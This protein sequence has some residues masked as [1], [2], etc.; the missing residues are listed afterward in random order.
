MYRRATLS[1]IE[2]QLVDLER[3]HVHVVDQVVE[4]TQVV[5][6]GFLDHALPD[7]VFERKD[8]NEGARGMA[9]PGL[10]LSGE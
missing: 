2:N 3:R 6:G 9:I 1:G 7:Q 10:A 5:E 8:R 4:A